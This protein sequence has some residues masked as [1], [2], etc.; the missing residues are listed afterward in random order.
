VNFD[1]EVSESALLAEA[2][3]VVHP[4]RIV[5]RQAAGGFAADLVR[6]D[7]RV[8]VTAYG[9]GP[10]PLLAVLAAEQ[11]Y[12]V[13]QGGGRCVAG[14]TYQDKARERVRRG[15]KPRR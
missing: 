8:A 10:D 9:S 4:M 6:T 2:Q 5:A 3:A 1:D 11:R 14:K 12:L 15:P 13:E 7:G